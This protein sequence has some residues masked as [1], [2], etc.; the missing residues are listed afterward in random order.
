MLA[1][2][3]TYHHAD[4]FRSRPHR[5]QGNVGANPTIGLEQYDYHNLAYCVIISL[6]LLYL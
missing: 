3:L 4:V 1:Y 6:W 2:L 5:K